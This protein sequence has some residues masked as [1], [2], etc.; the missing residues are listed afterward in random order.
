M[1]NSSTM[2]SESGLQWNVEQLYHQLAPRLPN[3]SVEVVS[4]IPST[5]TALLER[6]RVATR[7]SSEGDL[8]Q[9]RRS[10]ESLAFGRRTADHQPCLLVAEHQTEGRGR[11]GRV[12]QSEAGASLT[13]SLAVPLAPVDWSGFSLA[14]GVALADALDPTGTSTSTPWIGIKWP[15]DLWLM[16][17][18]GTANSGRKLG[19]LLIETVPAGALRLAVIGVG[20]NVLPL[21]IDRSQVASG[22]ACLEELDRQATAPQVLARIA[23]PLVEAL[24]RFE[25][26]GFAGFAERFAARDVL[27]G[28]AV[29]A[30]AGLSDPARAATGVHGVAEGVSGNGALRLRVLDELREVIAGDVS[31]RLQPAL[32]RPC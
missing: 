26:E 6:A 10:T 25:R 32:D 11:Q 14:V 19:G 9:V 16:P 17:P 7:L 28:C 24:Q 27:R 29:Q 3:L 2:I 4:Q 31:V 5:N 18:G 1:N 8:A 22:F 23:L 20:L 13:F 21:S 30:G 15:N 12:W